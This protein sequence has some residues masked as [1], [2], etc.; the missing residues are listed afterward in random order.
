MSFYVVEVAHGDPKIAGKAVYEYATL[1][2][3]V[4]T[5]HQK[6]GTAMKSE[7]YTETLLMVVGFDG[8]VYKSEYYVRPQEPSPEV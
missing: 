2:E 6:M 1:D 5:W 8:A 4:A 3:A 7:F